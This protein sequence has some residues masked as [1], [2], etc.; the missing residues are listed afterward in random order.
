MFERLRYFYIRF[1]AIRELPNIDSWHRARM[2]FTL[3]PLNS[4]FL[5]SGTGHGI[6]AMIVDML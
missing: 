5:T 3:L 4:L 2:V 1:L 6:A